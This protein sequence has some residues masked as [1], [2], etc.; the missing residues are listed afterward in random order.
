MFSEFVVFSS[1]LQLAVREGFGG[2]YSREKA[3]FLVDVIADFFKET[4]RCEIVG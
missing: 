3:D 4:S 2:Q 1:V